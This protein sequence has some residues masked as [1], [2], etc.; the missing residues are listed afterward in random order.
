MKQFETKAILFAGPLNNLARR[1]NDRSD[2]VGALDL[3]TL[4]NQQ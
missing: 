1:Q 3:G 4:V 2:P